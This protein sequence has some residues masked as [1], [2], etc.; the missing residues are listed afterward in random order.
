MKPAPPAAAAP[1]VG[2][3]QGSVQHVTARSVAAI[4]AARC[5]GAALRRAAGSGSLPSF[6][7]LVPPR[8]LRRRRRVREHES[9]RDRDL[10]RVEADHTARTAT[11]GAAI[12]A[13]ALTAPARR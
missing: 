7:T 8:H 2:C 1:V 12:H 11:A 4:A 5:A 9:V 6:P 13:T 3:S 10:R